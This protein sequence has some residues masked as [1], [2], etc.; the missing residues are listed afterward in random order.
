MLA[1]LLLL[2][3]CAQAPAPPFTHEAYVWQRQWSAPLAA[4]LGEA[5]DDFAAWRVLVL[6]SRADGGLDAIA[7]DREALRAAGR[8][9]VAVARL[10]G[11]YPEAPPTTLAP[12]L[13]AIAAALEADGI[14]VAGLEVDHDCATNRLAGYARWL[15]E[16]RR[17]LPPG[18]RLSIT[19]LPAWLDGAGLA[20]VLD[21]T[22][23][24]VLQVHAV[25]Q[26]GEGLF[27]AAAAEH[28]IRDFARRTTHPFRI[29]LPAYGARVGF[30]A[31][32]RATGVE[33][34]MPREVGGVRAEELRVA[35]IEVV[36]LLDALAHDRP[37]HLA[38][39]VWFRL[40]LAGDRRAWSLTTLRAVLHGEPL[41]AR[42]AVRREETAGGAVDLL[43]A[44]TGN[45]DAPPP[46][47][48]VVATGCLA[49]D[50]LAGYRAEP[51]S[52]RWLLVAEADVWIQ[53]GRSRRVAWLRCESMEKVEIDASP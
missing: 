34:E 48:H 14:A 36:R 19:A 28:W 32:G 33:S 40:P 21:Q 3:A 42:W 53:A 38:G 17:A 47:L 11:A 15:G 18:R 23:E 2:A 51:S 43:I 16:L 50:A 10:A 26:P 52:G 31:D 1:M 12:R 35:P 45:L 5:R 49:A 7:I 24:A 41:A 37:P 39:A 4:A 27:A 6:Q 25:R 44:N 9:V 20:D 13:A 22:D 30:A 46:A 29:A 8:P